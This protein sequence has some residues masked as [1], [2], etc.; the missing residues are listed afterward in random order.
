[1]STRQLRPEDAHGRVAV[2]ADYETTVWSVLHGHGELFGRTRLVHELR[3]SQRIGKGVLIKGTQRPQRSESLGDLRSVTKRAIDRGPTGTA[4]V[5]A[6]GNPPRASTA[7]GTCSGDER[8]G[9]PGLIQRKRA[10]PGI[11]T[12]N[13]RI[14]SPLLCH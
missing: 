10:P 3:V 11:R 9:S 2:L 6:S 1:M 4:R 13:L 7:A 5:A 14:K 8:P 12:Q